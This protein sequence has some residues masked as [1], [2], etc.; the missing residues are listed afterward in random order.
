MF[1]STLVI[2]AA[3]LA[4]ADGTPDLRCGAYCLYVSLKALDAQVGTYQ[5]FEERLG[6]PS[7][8]GYSLGE[9]QQTAGQY[10]MQT[11]AVQTNCENL[12]RRPGRFA[13][14]AHI[15]GNH[16]VNLSQIDAGRVRVIDPPRDNL[17]P[18]DTLRSQWDGT[19]L[20]ISASPLLA[21]EDLPRARSW[22][23]LVLAAAMALALVAAACLLRARMSGA[24]RGVR[25]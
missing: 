22:K 20:L 8:D 16:F 1:P 11:L 6:G 9:L 7:A 18:V 2:A 13:C 10:G 25:N 21:E 15:S 5:E 17:I 12:R 3:A 4:A 24:R 19:A 14:I 23:V